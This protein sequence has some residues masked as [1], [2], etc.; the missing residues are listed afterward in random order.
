[1]KKAV[2]IDTELGPVLQESTTEQGLSQDDYDDFD[3]FP[4]DKEDE[5]R[6]GGFLLFKKHSYRNTPKA[7]YVGWWSTLEAA[8]A[9][10][11]PSIVEYQ[12]LNVSNG[13]WTEWRAEYPI[14]TAVVVS[15]IKGD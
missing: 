11:Q 7:C 10:M 5:M 15:E 3:T 13:T 4:M 9:N 12:V 2:Y 8:K 14:S 1:M 6:G